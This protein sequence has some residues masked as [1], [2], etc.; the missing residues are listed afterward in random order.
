MNMQ[1]FNKIT[2]FMEI[3]M[4]TASVSITVASSAASGGIFP[5]LSASESEFLLQS[6]K[7]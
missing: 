4:D 6:K 2:V 1:I 5:P 7:K 3:Q